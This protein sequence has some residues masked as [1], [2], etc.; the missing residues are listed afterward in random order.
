MFCLALVALDL[1]FG[2]ANLVLQHLAEGE[3]KFKAGE[4][5]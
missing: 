4:K 3:E 2:V 5:A 1:L